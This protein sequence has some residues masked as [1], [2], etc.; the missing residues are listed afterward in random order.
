MSVHMKKGILLISVA[1]PLFIS[2]ASE[3]IIQYTYQPPES[4]GDGLDVGTSDEVSID[5]ALIEKAVN[6]INRGKYNEV[7][8]MLIFKDN[9]LVLEE[10]FPGHEY[11]WEAAVSLALA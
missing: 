11:I 9:K 8:S 1:S 6:D 7:H 5:L 10:Y 2:C 3:P 4:I